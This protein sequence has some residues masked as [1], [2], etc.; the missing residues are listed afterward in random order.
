[1]PVRGRRPFHQ[2]RS[3]TNLDNRSICDRLAIRIAGSGGV[4]ITA[5]IFE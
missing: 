1:M 2:A 3:L 5:G 4:T